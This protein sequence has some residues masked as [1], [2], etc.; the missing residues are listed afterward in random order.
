MFASTVNFGQSLISP[1]S[2]AMQ[3]QKIGNQ[4]EFKFIAHLLHNNLVNE[5]QYEILRLDTIKGNSVNFTDSLWYYKGIFKY[6]KKDYSQAF[7]FF[8]N[9]SNQSSAEIWSSAKILQYHSIL[10][11]PNIGSSS[12]SLSKIENIANNLFLNATTLLLNHNPQ[13]FD[14][15]LKK[16]NIDFFQRKNLMMISDKI[17]CHNPKSPIKAAVLSAV[18]PGLGKWYGGSRTEA[19]SLFL[20]CSVMAVQALEGYSK[21]AFKSPQFYIYSSLFTIFY[22]GGILG[23]FYS[24]KN[25]EKRFYEDIDRQVFDILDIHARKITHL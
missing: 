15:L 21:Q 1:D 16:T 14:S 8:S 23:S 22:G 3:I 2:T 17:V 12:S 13:T 24:V 20:I 18:I 4:T 5:A 9:V 7:V 6:Q 19:S 11:K 25:K 10:R